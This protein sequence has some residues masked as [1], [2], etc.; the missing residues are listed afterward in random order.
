MGNVGT[1][2]LEA[3]PTLGPKGQNTKD[4]SC[5]NQ[6]LLSCPTLWKCNTKSPDYLFKQVVLP[7]ET[8]CSAHHFDGLILMRHTECL[9]VSR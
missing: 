2:I 8:S 6:T 4:H 7:E 3:R 5:F 9:N 1:S